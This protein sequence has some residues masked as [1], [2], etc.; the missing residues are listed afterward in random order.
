MATDISHRKMKSW[1]GVIDMAS[2]ASG[3]I[4]WTPILDVGN[5]MEKS[6]YVGIYMNIHNNLGRGTSIQA[7]YALGW[8]APATS[9]AT[10]QSEASSMY[11]ADDDLIVQAGTSIT[12]CTQATRSQFGC[13][14]KQV[15][16]L[17][18]YM[19]LS[20]YTNLVGSTATS[21]VSWAVTCM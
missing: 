4:H 15:R 8:D 13:Y 7:A 21:R 3:S 6:D 9:G 19:A 5:Y 10:P 1:Q 2:A 14:Y 17:A 18:P 11:V 12:G 20:I 16:C